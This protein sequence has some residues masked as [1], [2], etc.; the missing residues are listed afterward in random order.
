MQRTHGWCDHILVLESVNQ[1]GPYVS[2]VDE[3]VE[4]QLE[5]S[6]GHRWI[7]P[8][9]NPSEGVRRLSRAS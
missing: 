1:A 3:E 5:L 4:T 2:G 7:R 9:R 6:G 8:P